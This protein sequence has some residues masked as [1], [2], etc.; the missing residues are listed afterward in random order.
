MYVQDIKGRVDIV[1]CIILLG[2]NVIVVHEASGVLNSLLNSD[3][4]GG[5]P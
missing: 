3:L 5:C 2:Q 1:V 4:R